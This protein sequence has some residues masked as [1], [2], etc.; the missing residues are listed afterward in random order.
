MS[1][2]SSDS[3]EELQL[4]ADIKGVDM[5]EGLSKMLDSDESEDEENKEGEKEDEEDESKPKKDGD[6]DADSSAD[7]G[8]KGK[9]KGKGSK[10]SSRATTP[11][12]EEGDDKTAR[13]EKRKAI[14]DNLLD[15]NAG[16]EPSAKKSRMDLFGQGT[17]SSAS[18]S[19]GGGSG[20]NP[21]PAAAGS[22]EA[23][24]EED[25]KRYL[26]RKPMTTTEILKK[27]TK[28]SGKSKDEVMPMLV[29]ALKR[30]NPH[31]QKSKGTMYLSLR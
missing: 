12:P 8:K 25:V 9:K 21:P 31:K 10:N 13:A 3:E 30:I 22:V 27:M 29:N 16:P 19:S 15:P 26:A 1:D 23:A 14:V 28:K 11:T 17:S 18:G 24:F 2:E 5:D 6:D 7:A 4:K 20:G